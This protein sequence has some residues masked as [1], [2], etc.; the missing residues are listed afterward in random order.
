M[1]HHISNIPN[2]LSHVREAILARAGRVL[3]DRVEVSLSLWCVLWILI[4]GCLVL[5]VSAAFSGK[6]VPM[7][8]SVFLWLP[9]AWGLFQ[10]RPLARRVSLVLLW[11]A[12]I[13]LPIGVIN[14]F[15]AMDGL[16][17]TDTPIWRLA[18]PVFGV[19]AVAL[20]MAHILGRHKAAF[21]QDEQRE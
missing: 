12:I 8:F 19:V 9:L 13:F 4:T 17:S 5:A 11:L 1:K 6:I 20:Y 14:P 10:R 15:A 7:M 18:V 2:A 21:G 16:V 3:P